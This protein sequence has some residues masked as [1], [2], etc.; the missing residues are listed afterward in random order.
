MRYVLLLLLAGCAAKQPTESQMQMLHYFS[1]VC[2]QQGI[3]PNDTQAM[4]GCIRYQA[5]KASA[6]YQRNRASTWEDF[7]RSMQP[8]SVCTHQPDGIGGYNTICR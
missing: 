7:G 5:A 4:R 6:S 3:N 1:R 2:E 8:Q